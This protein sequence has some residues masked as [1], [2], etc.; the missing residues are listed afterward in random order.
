MTKWLERREKLYHYS[1]FVN[2]RQQQ[3]HDLPPAQ[4]AIGPPQAHNYMF[5]MKMAQKPLK[6]RVT[7]VSLAGDFGA[8]TFQ[9]ALAEFIAQLTAH[10]IIVGNPKKKKVVCTY[11]Y[12]PRKHSQAIRMLTLYH[13]IL[14]NLK[15]SEGANSSSS[16]TGVQCKDNMPS[17]WHQKVPCLSNSFTLSSPWSPLQP[18]STSFWAP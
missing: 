8:L 13:A 14:H 6:G 18:A 2:W 16:T 5:T 3:D 17:S 11:L 4:I 1:V 10:C 12:Q 7:F 9:D 15:G